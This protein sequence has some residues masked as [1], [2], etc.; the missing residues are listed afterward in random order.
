MK[1]TSAKTIRDLMEFTPADLK[2]L[3]GF[4]AKAQEEVLE[5]LAEL[6]INKE[7]ESE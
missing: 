5:K 6:G 1:S 2:E 4:G 7:K 3:K